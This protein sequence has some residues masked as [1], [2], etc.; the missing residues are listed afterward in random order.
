MT[1]DTAAS[2]LAAEAR[3]LR[4]V[5]ESATDFAIISMARDGT[6]TDWNAGA[7]LVFGWTAEEAVGRPASLIFTPEDI[8]AGVPGLELERALDEDSARDERWH[9]RKD[10]GRFWGSGKVTLLLDEATGD[11]EGFLKILTDRTA[12]RLDLERREQT[13]IALRGSEARLRLALEAGRMAIW[14]IDLITD[15]IQGSPALN[16]MLGFAPDEPLDM[17]R[18]RR[19]YLPG[20][21]DRLRAAG[22]AAFARGDRYFQHEL[23]YRRPDGEVLAFLLRA[24]LILRNRMPQGVLGVL[25]DITERARAEAELER[26]HSH[27]GLMVNELNHRVK[28]SLALVQS[29]AAQTLRNARSLEEARTSFTERLIAIATAH[30]LLTAENWEGADLSEVIARTV[31]PH[32]G[33]NEGRFDVEGPDVRLQPRT[34]LMLSMALHELGTNAVKYGALSNDTGHIAIIWTVEGGKL[35]LTWRESGGPPVRP[36]VRRGFGT[37][38]VEQGLAP[39]I[40]GEAKIAYKPTGVVCTIVAPLAAVESSAVKQPWID[41]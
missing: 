35:H 40:R 26:S 21:Q 15:E 11:F 9:I 2:D 6:I 17:A 7:E 1:S 8:E 20:E 14:E 28:N 3:R 24:E 13:E 41:V 25:I 12:V 22:M 29:V 16:T 4:A 18:V 10:G 36:P 34:A 37:R 27:L 32:R 30:D 23:R 39:E 38:L 19:H 33:S 5:M 31:E